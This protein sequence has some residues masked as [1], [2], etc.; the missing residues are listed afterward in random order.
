[1]KNEWK[2]RNVPEDIGVGASKF[3]G[4]RRIFARIFPNLPQKFLSDFSYKFSPTKIMKTVFW[5]DRQKRSSRVSLQ[6]L[7]AI[8]WNINNIGRHFCPDFQVFF[9]FF[10]DCFPDFWHI[11][12]FLGALLSPAPHLLH[13]CQERL[14]T[15]SI[16]CIKSDKNRQTNNEFRDLLLWRRPGHNLFNYFLG[17]VQ[18]YLIRW[19]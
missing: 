7:G 10:Q 12:T 8:L 17:S 9:S 13:H 16:W 15:P 11:K 5:Y 4:V 2:G 6:T 3:L 1:M 19:F 14:P 18:P